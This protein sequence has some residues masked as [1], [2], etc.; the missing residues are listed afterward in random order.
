[1]AGWVAFG[2]AA[3]ALGVPTVA[4]AAA[5]PART[6]A[7]IDNEVTTV[8]FFNTAGPFGSHNRTGGRAVPGS[9]INVEIGSTAS[10]QAKVKV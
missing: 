2:V 10:A 4:A 5:P 6:M 9:G 7:A 3:A 1:M 8:R